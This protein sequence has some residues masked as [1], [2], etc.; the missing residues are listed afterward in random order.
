MAPPNKKKVDRRVRRTRKLLGDALIE[1]II[2][3]GYESITIQD[4][5]KQ[6]DVAR[7]TFYK[8]YKDKEDLLFQTVTDILENLLEQLPTS[9]WVTEEGSDVLM[10]DPTS[11]LDFEHVAQYADFY[12][13]ILGDH[14]SPRFIN[15]IRKYMVETVKSVLF[16]GL[17]LHP[18]YPLDLVLHLA[19]GANISI[20]MWWLEHDMPYTPEEMGEITYEILSRGIWWALGV[21]PI[22]TQK[23]TDVPSEGAAANQKSD[24]D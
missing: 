11:S 3:K 1:L 8:H 20:Y 17:E 21:P 24:S 12:R 6:A 4:I 15:H 23:K 22:T 18:R 13:A 10:P 19:T 14:G 16:A 2:E 5:A 7:T 9:M